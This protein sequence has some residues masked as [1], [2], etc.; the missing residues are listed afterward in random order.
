MES[1][2]DLEPYVDDAVAAFLSKLSKLQEQPINMALWAQLFAFDVVGEVTFSKRFGFMDAGQD[3][4]S[5]A[6][7]DNALRS[8]AWVGQVPWLYWL[9]DWI[10]PYIGNRLGITARHGSLRSF[11]AKEVDARKTRGSDH[12]DILEKLFEVHRDKPEEMNDMAVL[13]MATSNVFAGSDTTAISIGSVLYHLCCNRQAKDKLMEEIV[14][15]QKDGQIGKTVAMDVAR[16]MPYLQACL[17]EALRLFPAVGMTLPRVTP[18]EGIEI[19]G[20]FIP[21]GTVVGANPWVV[22]QDKDVFGEDVTAF[23]PERWIESDSSEMHRFFFAFGA[24]ARVCLGKNLGW[25]EM[26]KLI[27]LL[28]LNFDIELA[29]P[30]VALGEKAWWFVKQEGLIM[31]VRART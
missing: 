20:R 27:P 21:G 14:A 2:K 8:A 4:G 1:L 18:P 22:H 13:S 30:R 9:H 19:D 3:D 25:L 23:R 16:A 10:S 7:I 26:S 29:D 24:G 12:R 17:Y 5:F 15:T 6:Q 11:A 28:L 31:K